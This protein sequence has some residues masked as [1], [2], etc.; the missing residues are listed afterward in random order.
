[1]INH[2]I[3]EIMNDYYFWNQVFPKKQRGVNLVEATNAQ[4]NTQRKSLDRKKSGSN[5]W[6]IININQL[7]T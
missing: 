2:W 7:R 4:L 1:M 6:R 5:Y 3:W